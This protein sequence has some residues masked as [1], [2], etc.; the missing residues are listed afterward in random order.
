MWEITAELLG[1]LMVLEIEPRLSKGD[2]RLS[3]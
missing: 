2:T 1:V 3:P